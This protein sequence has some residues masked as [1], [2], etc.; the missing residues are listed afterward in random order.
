MDPEYGQYNILEEDRF[1]M[2]FFESIEGGLLSKDKKKLYFVGIIDILTYYGGK[3]QIEYT[4]KHIVYGNG[5]SC[6][7]P[8]A[9]GDRFLKYMQE[10]VFL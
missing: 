3:K 10:K 9:Y 1:P 7:P 6:V 4:F 8:K 5:I 2:T